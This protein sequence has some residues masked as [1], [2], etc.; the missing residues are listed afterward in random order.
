MKTSDL[1]SG[2][3]LDEMDILLADDDSEEVLI[4]EAALENLHYPYVLRHANTVESLF[5]LL[6]EKLPYILFLDVH[7][8][9]M[10]GVS[11]IKDIR[12]NAS[13]D[14]LPVIMYTSSH[15]P[16]LVDECFSHRANFYFQKGY[17]I[18]SL[19]ENLRKVFSLD[20]HDKMHYPSREN[21]VLG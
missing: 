1:G 13:Y 2:E 7:M 19:T 17:T 15:S 8:P 11:C 9:C 6:K 10:D 21:F 5:V 3:T 4:F 12:K 14:N 20:W 16:K 18:S